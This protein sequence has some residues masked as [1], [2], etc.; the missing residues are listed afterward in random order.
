MLLWSLRS[1]QT[2]VAYLRG[3]ALA[4]GQVIEA[5]SERS[6]RLLEP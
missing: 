4:A 1:D 3:F 2:S 5:H 6:T